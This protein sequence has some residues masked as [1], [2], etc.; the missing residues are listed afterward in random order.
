MFHVVSTGR[1]PHWFTGFIFPSSFQWVGWTSVGQNGFVGLCFA[2]LNVKM[3]STDKN[4]SLKPK[5]TDHC[6]ISDECHSWKFKSQHVSSPL[7]VCSSCLCI[8]VLTHVLHI[9]LPLRFQ[10][11]WWWAAT[12]GCCEYS[13]HMPASPARRFR[14]KPSFWRSSF[15]TPSSRWKWASLSRKWTSQTGHTAT[16]ESTRWD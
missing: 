3:V 9:C 13:P 14:R 2:E 7:H 4:L 1:N 8:F 11:R 5:W 6:L 15:R 12:W 10:T 16:E